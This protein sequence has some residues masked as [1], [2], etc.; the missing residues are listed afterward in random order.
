MKPEHLSA[1]MFLNVLAV[2]LY[3]SFMTIVLW[4][5]YIHVSYDYQC[6]RCP[7]REQRKSIALR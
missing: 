6:P 4:Q 1:K 2:I 3:A 7:G 5:A